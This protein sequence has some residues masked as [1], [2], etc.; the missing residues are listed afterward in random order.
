MRLSISHAKTGIDGKFG[1]APAKA[2]EDPRIRKQV[3]DWR[4]SIGG[5]VG[6]TGCAICNASSAGHL[7][8]AS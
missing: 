1:A 4:D 8:A 3:L 7:I 5:K 2:F 6:M